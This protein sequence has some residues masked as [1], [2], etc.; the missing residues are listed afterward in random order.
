MSNFTIR[1]AIAAALPALAGVALTL[2]PVASQAAVTHA[3][4][5]PSVATGPARA[6]GAAVTIT[7][8]ID[9]HD[10]LETTYEFRYGPNPT[11]APG[12]PPAEHELHTTPVT[13]AKGTGTERIK[14]S[15]SVTDLLVGYHYRLVATNA[16]APKGVGGKDR[17][18]AP[19]TKIKTK[20][21]FELPSSFEPTLVGDPF[22]LSGTL[23]GPDNTNRMV[24]L[25]A[26]PYPY[27][28]AFTDVG[29]PVLTSATTGAFSF[30]EAHLTQSTRFRVATV[31]GTPVISDSFTQLAEVHVTLKVRRSKRVE[32]IVRLYGTVSP[33][34]VGAHVF[35]QL[36]QEPKAKPVKGEKLEKN[37]RGAEK[38]PQTKFQTRFQTVVKRAGKGLAR[39]SVIVDVRTTGNYRAL[40]SLPVGPLA[41]GPSETV[42]LHAAPKGARKT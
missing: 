11:S 41:S 30:R 4:H 32:G 2:A 23:T 10:E 40:V 31:T 38:E 1:R 9:T 12:T 19:T 14:V 3:P 7:G 37:S 18:Y 33:A 16:A 39:F 29:T 21:G 13:L 8:T 25:Q 5:P 20:S 17:I 34:E 42:H 26:S 6:V 15:A 28:A 36:E 27:T 22:E 24:V 35:L